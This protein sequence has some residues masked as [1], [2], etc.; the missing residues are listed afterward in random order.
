MNVAPGV[1]RHLATDETWQLRAR[2]AARWLGTSA[3]LHGQSAI[4]WW[5]LEAAHR[6]DD[7][8]LVT[9]RDRRGH[10]GPFV[11]H[12]VGHWRPTDF[13][14]HDGVRL[15][16][17][18]VAIVAAASAGWEATR[19]ERAIDEAVR[20][21]ILSLRALSAAIDR[22]AGS[23]HAGVRTMRSLLLDSGGESYLER[24]FLRLVRDAQLP[25]PRCQVVHRENGVHIARVDFLF[26]GTD[27]VVEVTGRLGHVSD[28]E[29]QR[30]ARRRNSLQRA[31]RVVLEFTTAD[32]LDGREYVSSTLRSWLSPPFTSP[33]PAAR[34]RIR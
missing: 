20:R 22:H 30:D 34:H 23:G 3:G 10:R 24:R 8:H 15:Q 26:P 2:A 5:G 25:R 29:R 14:R 11:I 12:T 13:R 21:R 9:R 4:A 7:V 27:L 6:D 32:V 31:G 19:L 1:W 18:A 16:E 33:D 17:P 28:S